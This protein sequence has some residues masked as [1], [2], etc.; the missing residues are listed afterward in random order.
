MLFWKNWKDNM[1]TTKHGIKFSIKPNKKI[2]MTPAIK[3]YFLE[4]ERII[5]E[6]FNSMSMDEF[7]ELPWKPMIR[8]GDL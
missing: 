7:N 6:N 1:M 3:K 2:K 8:K 5:A 4:C